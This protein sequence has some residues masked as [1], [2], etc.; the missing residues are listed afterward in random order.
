MWAS[1]GPGVGTQRQH[2]SSFDFKAFSNFSTLRKDVQQHLVAVYSLLAVSLLSAAVGVY[3]HLSFNLGGLLTTIANIVC[4]V[5]LLS[6]YNLPDNFQQRLGLFF[7][8]SFFQ[9]CTVGLLVEHV[10]LF[11]P[12][13]LLTAFLGTSAIFASFTASALMSPRRSYLYLGGLLGSAL[14]TMAMLRLGSMFMGGYNKMFQVELYLGLLVMA[15]YV[16]FDTQLIVEKATY[17]V[18][19]PIVDSLKL[20]SDFVSMFVRLLIILSRNSE[21]RE[22]SKSNRRSSQQ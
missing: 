3:A 9:G 22:R 19:D 16:L 15:G 17:G 13:V 12:S 14:S 11:H 7:G 1:T 5:W 2:E 6:M 4:V 20:Y 10:L 21:Q 18:K 8:A